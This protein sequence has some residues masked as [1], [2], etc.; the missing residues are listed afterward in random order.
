MLENMKKVSISLNK[1]TSSHK[2]INLCRVN[3]LGDSVMYRCPAG[4]MLE[5][6]LPW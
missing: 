4:K 5:I 3:E 2:Y 6:P 1:H